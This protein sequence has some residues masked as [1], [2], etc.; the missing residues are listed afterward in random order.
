MYLSMEPIE[1]W[2]SGRW[3]QLFFFV[4]GSSP[5]SYMN[6]SEAGSAESLGKYR[7]PKHRQIHKEAIYGNLIT[8]TM[9]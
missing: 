8:D 6:V 1:R 3:N 4:H 7:P 5:H 2:G 9:I